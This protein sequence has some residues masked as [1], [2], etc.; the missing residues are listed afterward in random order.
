[1]LRAHSYLRQEQSYLERSYQKH[2]FIMCQADFN[3]DPKVYLSSMRFRDPCCKRSR[4]SNQM[5][6]FMNLFKEGMST[7]QLYDEQ[8]LDLVL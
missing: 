4:F 1:M 5:Q 7:N 2:E 8:F 6:F 3:Q